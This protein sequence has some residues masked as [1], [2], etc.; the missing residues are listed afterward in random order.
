MLPIEALSVEQGAE[1]PNKIPGD[2]QKLLKLKALRDSLIRKMVLERNVS[3][4]NMKLHESQ[5]TLHE[6]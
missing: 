2:G 3:E 6:K 5:H 4:S 1:R